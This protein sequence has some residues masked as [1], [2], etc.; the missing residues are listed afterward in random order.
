M[1]T[2][3]ISVIVPA[4]NSAKTIKRC[5]NAIL[6][7]KAPEFE[8]II[9]DDASKDNTVKILGEFSRNK[10]VRVIV[11]PVNRGAPATRNDGARAARGK[12]MVFFDGDIVVEKDTVLRLV[13][14]MMKNKTIGMTQGSAINPQTRQIENVGHYMTIFGFPYDLYGPEYQNIQTPQ[15]IFGTK[16]VYSYRK[17]IFKVIGGQD[18]DY[19]FHGEDTDLSWRVSLA[20]YQIYYIPK[21]RA[22]HY[23]ESHEKRQISHYMFLEGSKNQISNIIKNTPFWILIIMLP[24]N[25]LTWL[26]FSL[27]FLLTGQFY[28]C[29]CV[30]QG[31]WWSFWNIGR[32]IHKRRIVKSYTVKGNDTSK[33]MFGPHNVFDIVKGG[34]RWFL[35]V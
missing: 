30:L 4:Y 29:I 7:S 16:A 20:G 2:P 35:Y 18:E 34:M 3:Q 5:V 15:R 22:L 23:H 26:V 24:L 1:K 9:V 10:K 32:T 14:P 21:A 8:V 33:I 12:Y 25:I 11:H 27:K 31:L 13:E 6:A 19:I 28:F 17:E